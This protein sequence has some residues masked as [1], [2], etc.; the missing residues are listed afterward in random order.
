MAEGN[1]LLESALPLPFDRVRPEHV[2]PAADALLED[3]RA[4]MRAVIVKTP[5]T[6]EN[7]VAAF[8][9]MTERLD[10]A[11]GL[12]GH[13]ESVATEPALRDAYNAVQPLLSAFYSSIPL[14]EGLYRGI[15]EYA[16]T[17]EARSLTGARRRYLD[18]TLADFRRHGAELDAVGKERL[19]KIDVELADITLKFSQNTLDAT[20]SFDLVI[21][22]EARLAGLPEGAVEAARESAESTGKKG[23]RFTLAAPSYVPAMTYLEDAGI[24]EQLYRAFNTRATRDPWDNRP[25]VR[26]ILQ[27]RRE[28]A[29]L[30]GFRDFADL[31]LEDRMA[32]SGAAAR[33]FVHTLREKTQPFFE[34]ENDELL[35]FA[36][37]T[38]L[39]AWD[40][41]YQAEKLRRALYDFDEEALRPYFS[42]DR[43]LEGLF[44]V[45]R[46]LYGV[47]VERDPSIAW[48]PDVRT[49]RIVGDDGREISTFY[50]DVFPRSS[51]RDG[52]WMHGL[53]TAFRGRPRAVQALVA[54]VTPPVGDRP[55]LLNH[56]EVETMFHEFGHLLHHALGKVELRGQAGTNVAWDFVELPSQIMENWC[57]ER[58]AL[59]LFARHF[60]TGETIPDDLLTK[61]RRARTF[62][63][64]NQMMRQLGFAEADLALHC[65]LDPD[66]PSADPVAFARAIFAQHASTELPD[67]YAMVAS[68][69]HLFGSAV[70][71]AAAYYSYKWAEVLDADAFAAFR[72]HGVFSREVGD[73][74]R[75]EILARGD[76]DDPAVLYRRFA[77]REPRLEPL[78]ERSGLVA[79]P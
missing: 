55:A 74:F 15:K 24:R 70:G 52:A 60:Q 23:F 17:D 6:W 5:R 38:R 76:S 32:K 29:R 14:D 53:I 30:L 34:R 71:Y 54:N 21:E 47:S 42:L 45:A 1:P 10:D 4:R 16:E 37:A 66:D 19:S 27:L 2:R 31:V 61:M 49:F 64:A 59:D 46:R 72:E 11:M 68:F 18:K 79:A 50:V 58:E 36:G 25:L 75:S 3:A 26:R 41:S 9:V 69:G 43:V 39:A 56:R 40:V 77:G 48:H 13:L 44:E 28:R 63:A 78:F 62:R 67:D 35:R 73:R 57:W 12:V 65:D 33:A 8:D 51:K 20:N 22:D 7:T